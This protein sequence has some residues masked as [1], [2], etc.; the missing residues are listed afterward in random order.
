MSRR[1]QLDVGDSLNITYLKFGHFFQILPTSS[2]HHHHNFVRKSENHLKTSPEWPWEI[3]SRFLRRKKRKT[4]WVC[5][6]F[7]P[8]SRYHSI[9]LRN[10]SNFRGKFSFNNGS[11][12]EIHN[13]FRTRQNA[14]FNDLYELI[15]ILS[16]QD[17]AGLDK[18]KG[19]CG[20]NEGNVCT[21]C[22]DKQN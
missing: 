19:K 15:N 2:A 17:F 7:L 12:L 9:Y 13:Y 20:K 22:T 3:I 14:S 4:C 11:I 16:N 6:C 21:S 8:K 10:Y 18:I 5:G 1:L